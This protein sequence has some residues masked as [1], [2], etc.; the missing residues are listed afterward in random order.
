MY[1]HSYMWN[2]K[3]TYVLPHTTKYCQISNISCTLVDKKIVDH[4]DVVG[5][6]PVS[7]APTTSSFST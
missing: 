5:A 1:G 2:A 7:A 4:L 6:L 3:Y